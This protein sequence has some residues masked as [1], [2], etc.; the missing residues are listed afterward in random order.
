MLYTLIKQKQQKK[1]LKYTQYVFI[2]VAAAAAE[3]ECWDFNK[4]HKKANE[5]LTFE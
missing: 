5:K 2:V 4:T 1:N 3:L